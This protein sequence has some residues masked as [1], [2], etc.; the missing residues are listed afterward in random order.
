MAYTVSP[1]GPAELEIA[2]HLLCAGAPAQERPGRI[3]RFLAA[4]ADGDVN[5]SGILLARRRGRPVGV[6][7]VQ[8]LL[9]GSAV[10]L[11]PLPSGRSANA[12]ANAVIR[13]LQEHDAPLGYTFLDL[14]D[15]QQAEP[16]VSNGF[17]FVTRIIHM[18]RT[19]LP[20]PPRFTRPDLRFE[21]ATDFN[22]FGKTLLETYKGTLDV[23]E[24]CIDRPVAGIMD[25]YRMNQPDPPHWFIARN[26]EGNP[27]GVVMLT[28]TR[29]LKIWE[30]GYLG[31]VPAERGKR[32]GVALL[33]HALRFAAENNIHDLTLSVDERNEPALQ[34]YRDQS[35]RPYQWQHVFLWR[36]SW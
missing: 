16:L 9:G 7:V 5:P 23:P 12:L 29:A 22:E 1:A 32:I 33:Q 27:A 15:V 8:F 14:D 26:L 35:F 24:A 6:T 17:R 2:A 34:L 10:V 13:Q 36:P 31:V 18:I 25:G 19:G 20:A 30:L 3:E 21:P 28:V 4:I 11:P